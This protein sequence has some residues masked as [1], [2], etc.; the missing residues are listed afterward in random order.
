MTRVRVAGAILFLLFAMPAVMNA[1]A[2]KEFSAEM[3]VRPALGPS[4]TIKLYVGAAKLRMDSFRDGPEHQGTLIADA[5]HNTVTFV[6]AERRVYSEVSLD[7]LSEG[8][9]LYLDW[10]SFDGENPCAKL[11]N[12]FSCR[13]LAAV[14]TVNGFVCDKWSLV[15]THRISGSKYSFYLWFD[16]KNGLLIKMSNQYS[17]SELTIIKEGPQ[18]NSVF[19][20]PADF[21]KVDQKHFLQEMLSTVSPKSMPPQEH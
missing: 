15:S 13:K 1:Q 19:E 5:N 9:R 20:F 10:R 18:D 6:K 7:E 21:R 8:L 12:R 16:R 2:V 4:G 3:K 14:E 17:A 11:P